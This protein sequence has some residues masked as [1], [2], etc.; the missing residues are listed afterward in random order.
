MSTITSLTSPNMSP[1]SRNQPGAPATDPGVLNQDDFLKLLVAQ[2]QYQDPINP[3]SNDA[4]IGQAAQFS[5]LEQLT[6]LVKLTQ[7]SVS[8]LE[9]SSAPKTTATTDATSSNPESS[10]AK[11]S[12]SAAVTNAIATILP[13]EKSAQ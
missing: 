7:Q 9:A 2:L 13:A 1:V 3:V 5:Q 6:K 8:L 12:L 4:F 11:S 10:A